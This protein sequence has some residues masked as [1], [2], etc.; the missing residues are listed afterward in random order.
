MMGMR[1]QAA[2]PPDLTTWDAWRNIHQPFELRWWVDALARGH[3]DDAT[4]A[5]MWD[6]VYAFIKPHGH[7]LDIGAG[8]RPPF[9]PCT[10]IDPLARDYQ[11][12]APLWWDAVDA[13][14]RPAEHMIGA[15]RGCFDTVVCWNCI[16]HTIGW[17]DILK[18]MKAYGSVD[19]RY[20]I[21]TDF[22]EPF[23]GHPGFA[24]EEF[25][26]EVYKYF[27]PVETKEPFGRDLALLLKG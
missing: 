12:M 1:G 19:A 27:T 8:P 3:C 22:H 17:R 10:V 11:K 16:D 5:A 15:L 21:A 20:A 18:N 13:Y 25:I 24:R 7:I 6:P 2:K 9:L 23:I 4:H 14:A 26:S